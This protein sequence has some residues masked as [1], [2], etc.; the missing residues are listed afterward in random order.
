MGFL[1]KY[2][3]QFLNFPKK[4]RDKDAL[5]SVNLRINATQMKPKP[6]WSEPITVSS[7]VA[8]NRVKSVTFDELF[9]IGRA[10][11]GDVD[12]TLSEQTVIVFGIFF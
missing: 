11:G 3:K 9:E 5:S 7:T 6:F 8:S 2:K 12:G 4:N 1:R 10:K